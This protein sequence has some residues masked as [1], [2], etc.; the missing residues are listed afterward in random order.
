MMAQETQDQSDRLH[1]LRH[2]T[3]HVMADAVLRIFP[4]GKLGFGP[5]IENGFYYDFDLPRSLTT[6]DLGEIESQMGEIIGA[7]LPFGCREV[8]PEEAGSIFADQPYKMEQIEALSSG[9][10]AEQ[11]ETGGE[12]DGGLTV[13][14][15]DGFTDLCRGPHLEHTG[16]DRRKRRH[17]PDILEYLLHQFLL[18][19]CSCL[20]FPALSVTGQPGLLYPASYPL[21][22]APR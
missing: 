13:Y 7:S 20:T 8:T 12:H 2:S 5:P 4:A 15:H 10:E 17:F 9:T 3:A 21:R 1:R 11:S 22:V 18:R 14:A 19:H 16:H 6:D